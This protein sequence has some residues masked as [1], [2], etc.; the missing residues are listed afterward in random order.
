MHL[1]ISPFLGKK[2]I[3][4]EKERE[5]ECATFAEFKNVELKQNQTRMYFFTR[6]AEKYCGK[7]V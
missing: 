5:L 4:R 6:N 1:I 7:A 3:H 2:I